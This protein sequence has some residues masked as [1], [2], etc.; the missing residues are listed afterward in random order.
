MKV[1][2]VLFLFNKHLT[3]CWGE[4]PK[5]QYDHTKFKYIKAAY[6]NV[7]NK[8]KDT[9]EINDNLTKSKIDDLDIT[10]R[11]NDKLSFIIKQKI[12]EIDKKD[13]KKSQLRDELR[14]VAGIGTSKADELIKMGLTSI[15]QL[16]QKKWESYLNSGIILMIKNKPL[17]KIPYTTIKKL[18]KKLTSFQLA[19]VKLVGGFIRKKSFSKDIDV[20][21]V[22]NKK[23]IITQYIDYLKTKFSEIHV[24]A[25]GGNKASL[26]LQHTPIN[27]NSIYLKIDIFST[28][29]K[30][31][32]AMLLYAI[33]S[34]KSNI[35][36]RSLARRKGYI[37][38]Q[39]G[40]YKLKDYN[41]K[42]AEPMPVKSERDFFKI[43]KIPYVSPHN[44]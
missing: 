39:Y 4:T 33:G 26:I 40:L 27:T 10:P 23:T 41:T 36:M 37:L 43:L 9:Y 12:S 30:Y 18:E 20:M 8:I 44:R 32:H 14:N 24:Y 3:E 29:V 6:N 34:K 7:I 35:K 13:L 17:R 1:Y 28:P 2:E 22:S 42:N 16:S 19:S 25:K 21:I 38:N 31:Q 11:M 15:N 5:I